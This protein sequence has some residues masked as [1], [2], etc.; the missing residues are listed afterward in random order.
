MGALLAI[1]PLVQLIGLAIS[2]A[3]VVVPEIDRVAA[4]HLEQP[5]CI[6]RYVI[7]MHPVNVKA[8]RRML[9][10]EDRQ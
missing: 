10:K 2:G 5:K 7:I 4:R 6:V 8:L 3:G 9:A 1:I